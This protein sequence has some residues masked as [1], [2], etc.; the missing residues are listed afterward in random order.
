M[1]RDGRPGLAIV[2]WEGGLDEDAHLAVLVVPAVEE[3]AER[4]V[5]ELG[6]LAEE[7]GLEVGGGLA[8]VA[9]GAAERLGDDL[10]DDP[11]AEQILAGELERG[12]GLG[13]VLAAFPEDR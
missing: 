13:G 12:G 3:R 7:E 1:G 8:M 5:D 11:E 4:D 6:E 10:V 2:E 9:V